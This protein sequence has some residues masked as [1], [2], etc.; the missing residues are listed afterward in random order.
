MSGQLLPPPFHR[1]HTLYH[2]ARH[3][4]GGWQLLGRCTICCCCTYFEAKGCDGREFGAGVGFSLVAYWFFRGAHL[5]GGV[6]C[7]GII[8]GEE[9]GVVV[10]AGLLLVFC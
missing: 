5:C 3:T 9:G 4:V 6:G 1:Y 10:G 7:G 2:A 8:G